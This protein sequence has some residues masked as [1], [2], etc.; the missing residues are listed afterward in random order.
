MI[1]QAI[2]YINQVRQA[3]A[4]LPVDEIEAAYHLLAEAHRR[5]RSV[6]VCGNGG[7]AATASHLAVDLG[8]NTPNGP[9]PRM[10]ILSLTDNVPWLTALANDRGYEDCFSEQLRN[11]LRPDDVVIGISASGNSDNVVRAFELARANN[12]HRLA[13]VGFDGGHLDRLAT[14]RIWVDSWDYGIVE[15]MHLIVVHMLVS[16]FA[17]DGRPVDP[18]VSTSSKTASDRDTCPTMLTRPSS[19]RSNLPG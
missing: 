6:Y 2:E 13:L 15:S 5:D 16:M 1:V 14:H 4:L 9:G 8:K 11:Y 12:A 3:A 10:R 18:A 17:Q 19:V 7:S